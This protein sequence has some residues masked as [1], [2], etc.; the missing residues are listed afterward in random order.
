[1]LRVHGHRLDAHLAAREDDA[2]RN[3][4]T[5]RDE[6]FL[7]HYLPVAGPHPRDLCLRGLRPLG[8]GSTDC[9]LSA[10]IMGPPRHCLLARR[11]LGEG[12]C[13]RGLRPLGIGSTDCPL[14][15]A[16]T[17]PLAN[18]LLARRSLGDGGPWRQFM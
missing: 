1:G 14:S 7:E 4:A 12:G 11:S 18:C 9:P 6:D 5:V 17:G 10:A 15:A 16:I 13:L 2:Q 3:L 8:I